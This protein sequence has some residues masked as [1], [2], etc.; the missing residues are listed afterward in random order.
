[1]SRKPMC[2]RAGAAIVIVAS[3]SGRVKSGSSAT[4]CGSLDAYRSRDA[5]ARMIDHAATA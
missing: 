2:R 4:T 3:C 5:M 1:M